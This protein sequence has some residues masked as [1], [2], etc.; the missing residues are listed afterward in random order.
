MICI[1]SSGISG[2]NTG[3]QPLITLRRAHASICHSNFNMEKMQMRIFVIGNNNLIELI[4]DDDSDSRAIVCSIFP[5]KWLN[6]WTWSRLCSVDLS[7]C[8]D[9]TSHTEFLFISRICLI[10]D[11]NFP[12]Q[13]MKLS[14]IFHEIRCLKICFAFRAAQ[15]LPIHK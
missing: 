7:I 8:V 9:P 11:S 15:Y 13:N 12:K 1:S 14:Q 3:K 5:W 4:V 10:G 2:G 6:K